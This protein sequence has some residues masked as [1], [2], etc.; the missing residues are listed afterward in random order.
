MIRIGN[1]LNYLRGRLSFIELGQWLNHNTIGLMVAKRLPV[2]GI[3]GSI[4]VVIQLVSKC[5]ASASVKLARLDD[6][7][8]TDCCRASVCFSGGFYCIP[9]GGSSDHLAKINWFF[10]F[11]SGGIVKLFFRK[12][13]TDAYKLTGPVNG[14]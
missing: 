3:F 5:T 14:T 9:S 12:Q 2:S 8:T 1:N 11:N 10:Q 13:E 4:Q 6:T 7:Q